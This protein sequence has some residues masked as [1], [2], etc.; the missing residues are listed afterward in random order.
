MG[1]GRH[2]AIVENPDWISSAQL[3]AITGITERQLNYWVK[4]GIIDP[5]GGGGEGRG[6]PRKWS[7][8][9]V[10]IIRDMLHRIEEC[11]FDHN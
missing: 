1:R 5:E 4:K 11:P 9:D 7:R 3:M 2:P 10:E 6:R 8:G